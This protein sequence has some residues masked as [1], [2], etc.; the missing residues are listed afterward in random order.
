MK[1]DPKLPIFH[2]NTNV[3]YLEVGR[4]YGDPEKFFAEMGTLLV[5][6]KEELANS[7]IYKY[8]MLKPENLFFGGISIDKKYGGVH[9]KVPYKGVFINPFYDFGAK[10]LAGVR[11]TILNTMIHEIAHTGSMS[12][13]VEHNGQ[14]IKVANYLADASMMDYFRSLK[15]T[16]NNSRRGCQPI[17]NCT[18]RRET[19]KLIPSIRSWTNWWAR[20]SQSRRWRRSYRPTR[21]HVPARSSKQTERIWRTGS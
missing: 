10:T 9:I 5:E 20:P 3:D 7:G 8:D 11:E 6:M 1:Q 18:N 2:N 12:H 4:P 13:G 21:Q 19:K 15:S 16:W 14:M 17:F